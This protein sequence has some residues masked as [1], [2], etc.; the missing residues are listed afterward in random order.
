M[1]E[2]TKL[3]SGQTL[4]TNRD[5]E[6]AISEK[7]EIKTMQGGMQIRPTSAIIGYNDTSVRMS[8]GSIIHRSANTFYVN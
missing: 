3:Q 7:I 4:I 8:D 5:F 1:Q 6:K 2:K